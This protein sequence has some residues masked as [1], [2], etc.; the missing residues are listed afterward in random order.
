[1]R[2]LL[3]VMSA[4]GVLMGYAAASGPAAAQEG[5][6]GSAEQACTVDLRVAGMMKDIVSNVLLR[7]EKRPE[8]E[9]HEF[10]RDAEKRYATGQ[11][12][13][14]AAARHF[15]IDEATMAAEVE[16]LRHVNCSHGPNGAKRAGEGAAEDR[17]AGIEL[18]AFARDVAIHVVLH[19]LGHALVRE[20]D[21][22][23][24]SNEE[25]MADAF[26][27]HYLTM[28]LPDRALD[29]L[30]ARAKSLMIEAG[31]VP[32]DEWPVRGEHECDAR[33]A[34]QIAAW[35]IAADPVKYSALAGVVGMTEDDVRKAKD[36]G[37]E[38]HRSWRRMLAP[39]FMPPGRRSEEAR[40]V[41]AEGSITE[42]SAAELIPLL[43]S[44]ITSFDWHSQVSISFVGGEGGAAWSRSRR[45]I[46]VNSQYLRRFNNQGRIAETVETPRR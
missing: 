12:L 25:A 31:E 19:E 22:P 24:L 38:V 39:L 29:V 8:A 36:Y 42:A 41:V 6:A 34:F 5:G 1:M 11:D 16:S 7:S 43:E 21:L 9:V 35:A 28:H 30:M 20:F 18:S 33:R 32:R 44:A 10:L 37:S 46:T 4:V 13:M 45:T 26:A 17:G 2:E 3:R 23:I 15:K 40:V 27:T 14:R